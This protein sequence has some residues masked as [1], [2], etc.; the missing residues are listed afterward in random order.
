MPVSLRNREK[1]CEIQSLETYEH[2]I[3]G[4]SENRFKIEQ[5]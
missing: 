3:K 5:V 1:L 4:S 2:A